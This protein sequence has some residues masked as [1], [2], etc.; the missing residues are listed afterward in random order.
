VALGA[1]PGIVSYSVSLASRAAT[2][3]ATTSART[4]YLPLQGARISS[5]VDW[6]GNGCLYVRSVANWEPV[7][8]SERGGFSSL[9]KIDAEGACAT[10]I[11]EGLEPAGGIHGSP[12]R[13][14]VKGQWR[15]LRCSRGLIGY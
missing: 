14:G 3:V 4:L 9:A 1:L 5:A 10:A 7:A 8:G 12:G 11:L 6:G 2:S 13:L 15:T